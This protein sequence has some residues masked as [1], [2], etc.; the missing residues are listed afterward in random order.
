VNE[1]NLDNPKD[2]ERRQTYH[3]LL[4]FYQ[5]RQWPGREKWGEKR[6]TFNYAAIFIDKLTSYLMNGRNFTV[7]AM[8][9]NPPGRAQAQAAE[10]ALEQVHESNHLEQLDFETEIDCAILGDACYK[11]TWEAGE[12]SGF[13]SQVSSFGNGR[14][15]VT[16]PDIQGISAWWAGDDMSRVWK[17]ASKYALEREE[18]QRLYPDFRLKINDL[19][20]PSSPLIN[21]KT[22]FL[23]Q[24]SHTILEV[25][26]DTD[27]ELYLDN[28]LLEKKP[29]PYGFIPFVIFP[30][31]RSGKG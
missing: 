5:G 20:I 21:P 22:N 8:Q 18:L 14:V 2:S 4:D 25:W 3:S 17:V 24:S 30:K 11:V 27:F 31:T 1:L 6:L 10:M 28:M 13:K 16:A 12:V 23:N 19:R 29:N 9:D 15:R 7:E 26:T